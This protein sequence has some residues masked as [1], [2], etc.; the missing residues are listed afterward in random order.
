MT[1]INRGQF[2]ALIVTQCAMYTSISKEEIV[3]KTIDKYDFLHNFFFS[4]SFVSFDVFRYSVLLLFR[5]VCV[6]FFL[7]R[8]STITPSAHNYGL[9]L[10]LIWF[11]AWQNLGNTKEITTNRHE[12]SIDFL[13]FCRAK[14][15]SSNTLTAWLLIWTWY[16]IVHLL[17]FQLGNSW[18]YIDR[19]WYIL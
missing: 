2:L 9:Y 14:N 15:N 19:N 6:F 4:I 10:D 8:C 13:W 18:D 3:N 12:F 7:F 5:C 17:C 11:Y 16:T 1:N